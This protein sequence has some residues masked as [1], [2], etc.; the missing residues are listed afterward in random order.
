MVLECRVKKFLKNNFDITIKYNKYSCKRSSR[1]VKLPLKES[2]S[3]LRF[4]GL[5]H[6]D[7]NMF[8]KRILITEK[9]K[10][11]CDKISQLF[12]K[13]FT[14]ALNIFYDKNRNSY[15]CHV[16]NSVIFRYL[17][18]VLEIPNQSVRK[19][20][21]LPT[22][23]NKL[24][25]KFQK[26]YVGGLYDAEGWVTSRQAHVGL[27]ITNKDIRDFVSEILTRCGIKHTKSFRDR[28]PNIEY[29]IHIYGKDNLKK[30]QKSISFTHPLKITKISSFY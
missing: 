22:Y 26:E 20:I 6:G 29:E 16:K 10:D 30:F 12:E 17:I 24:Y 14:I 7:G 27:S 15:Y 2:K 9:N 13:I 5:L 23:M 3:L 19:N 8:N 28:R 25:L 18:E 4:L 1:H 11:F 21:S